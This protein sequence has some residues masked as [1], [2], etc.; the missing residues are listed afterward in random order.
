MARHAPELVAGM[1]RN[2]QVTNT[3]LLAK[4]G[5]PNSFDKYAGKMANN[6]STNKA[7]IAQGSVNTSTWIS[8]DG[9]T[10]ITPS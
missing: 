5:Y 8:V 9:A 7:F 1:D 2:T 10:T 4:G 3:Q 6:T